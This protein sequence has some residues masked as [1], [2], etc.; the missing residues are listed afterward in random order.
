MDYSSP[1]ELLH[2]AY[3]ED[4][5]ILIG[6]WGYQPEPA[7]LPAEYERLTAAA[8]AQS[9]RY[10]LQDIRRRSLNDPLITQWLLTEYFPDMARRLGGRLCVAYLVSPDLHALIV[11]QPGFAPVESYVG[12]PFAVAF[13]GEEGAAT[14]WLQSQ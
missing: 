11:A 1:T 3:R 6:R 2:L 8:L 4:L 10:W 7:A 13:F 5:K 12:R 9:S 14:D